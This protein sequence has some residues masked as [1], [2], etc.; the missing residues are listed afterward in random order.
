MAD[1]RRQYLFIN[2][3][4]SNSFFSTSLITKYLQ[5]QDGGQISLLITDSFHMEYYRIADYEMFLQ[6]WKIQNMDGSGNSLE[7]ANY[8]PIHFSEALIINV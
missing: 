7:F 5:I 2:R 8:E 6:N 1:P 3:F 4:I